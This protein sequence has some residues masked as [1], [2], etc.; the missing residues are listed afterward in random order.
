METITFDSQENQCFNGKTYESVCL[1]FKRCSN[2]VIENC[3]FTG[4]KLYF[5]NC[6]NP[7]VLRNNFL[8]SAKGETNTHAVQFNQCQG[9]TIR[10]N[11]FVEAIGESNM[12]DIVNIYRS[13]GTASEYISVDNNFIYGGGPHTSGGGIMLGDNFGDY[14]I[15]EKNILIAPGQYGIAIAGGSHNKI[16]NNVVMSQQYAYTNVGIYVWGVPARNSQVDDALV[17]EN[18][19]SWVNKAG[20]KNPWWQGANTSNIT[21]AHNDFHAEY[22]EPTKPEHIGC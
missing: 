17:E 15:A 9:G 20:R 14:Q 21:Q 2:I 1:Q 6:V 12:S 13:S 16:V 3:N 22:T 11:Y 4:C 5:L 18:T 19:V 7:R 10:Q 8:Y